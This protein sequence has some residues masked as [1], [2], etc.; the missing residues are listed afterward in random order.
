MLSY[1]IMKSMVVGI[2]ASRYGHEQATGVEWYSFHLLN[3]LIPLLGREHNTRVRL[4]APKDFKVQ[5]DVP[6]NVT[7]RIIPAKRLWTTLRLT[8]EMIVKPVDVLFVPSHTFPVF[9]PKKAI[10]TIHDVAFRYFK[11]CYSWFDYWLLHRSTKKA[12]RKAWRIIVPSEATKND[13]IELY[14]CKKEKIVVVPHGGPEVPRLLSWSDA[15]KAKLLQQLRLAPDDLF[16]AYIG[17]LE[18]K[19]NLVRL[20]EGF[21]RFLK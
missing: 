6:F 18:A 8:W 9:V 3:E 7:K 1:F 19:K 17:R 13:L 21:S 2:D 10:I 5:T 16:I 4:Y 11:E 12:V 15:K 14:K 20:V